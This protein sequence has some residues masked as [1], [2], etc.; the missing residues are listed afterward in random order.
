VTTASDPISLVMALDTSGSM[1][2]RGIESAKVAA[3]SFLLGM[4]SD[5]EVSILSFNNTV[6]AIVD[7]TQDRQDAGQKL[8]ALE[9]IPNS[10]TCLFDAAYQAV[11]NAAGLP[12]GRR[13][14]I[15]FTD[16]VDETSAGK[17]C[18]TYTADDV[19]RLA[20]QGNTAIPIYTL[21]L[22]AQIDQ[23]SLQRLA[24][25][26]GGRFQHAPTSDQLGTIFKALSEQLKSQYVLKYT[27]TSA[28]GNHTLVIQVNTSNGTAKD[29][30]NFTSPE[31]PT[32][33]L[34][35]SPEEG[36]SLTGKQ[37]LSAVVTGQADQV[38]KVIFYVGG[39]EVGQSSSAPYQVDFE[40]TSTF[41]GNT[42]V[43]A[44][45]QGAGGEEIA[46]Q[47]V[48]ITIGMPAGEDE[49]ASAT[50]QSPTA[51]APA[52][53][54]ASAPLALNSPYVMGGIA[55]VVVAILAFVLLRKRKAG[56]GSAAAVEGRIEVTASDDPGLV[57]K[58]FDLQQPLTRLGRLVSDNDLCFPQDSPVSKRHAIIEQQDKDFYLREVEQGT[59][60]GT[61][62]NDQEMGP[63]PQ[64]LH[65]GDEIRLGKRLKLRIILPTHEQ[66]N[67]IGGKTLDNIV[68]N[69]R[70]FD[71][72]PFPSEPE[73]TTETQ[74][75]I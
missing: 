72:I 32:G 57:G 38:K 10:G 70:T 33:I 26:T 34:I 16:G 75:Q 1:V 56:A 62:L 68:N 65:N 35:K 66:P 24:S 59:T 15:L 55:V 47:A 3:N 64:L 45:A 43:E 22:G 5:D 6:T 60:Y 17:T 51:L 18:S 8:A 71:G 7:F 20:T 4:G 58:T 19:I 48:H 42:T 9:V 25:T 14:V 63:E 21:G 12:S 36:Q 53:A 69:D 44:V 13:A 11:Q 46:R 49:D 37:T 31:M 50:A 67:E 73:N 54:D 52:Q 41:A 74:D 39:K 30:R 29:T 61:Y 40:F 23:Q 28:Q 2:G 27:T